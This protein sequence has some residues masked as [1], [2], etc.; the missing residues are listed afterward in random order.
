LLTAHYR[1]TF[2]F[3]IEGLQGAR[4]S[5]QRIDECVSK[6]RELA[7]GSTGTAD[8]SLVRKLTLPL[9]EDLNISGA[10]GAVFEWIRETNRKLADNTVTAEQAATWLASWER[11]DEV[12]GVSLP[13]VAAVPA[14]ITALVE[15]RQAARKAKDFKQADAIRE[16]LKALGWVLEDTPKGVRAKRIGS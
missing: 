16:Q 9:E 8:P 1:E 2:N 3:T 5:L 4:S 7:A 15:A 13:A 10:W 6:L 11:V 14:E 12:F